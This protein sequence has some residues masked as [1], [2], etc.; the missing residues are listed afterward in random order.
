MTPPSKHTSII[1]LSLHVTRRLLKHAA[2]KDLPLLFCG[3]Y[4]LQPDKYA[5]LH[6]AIA[7]EPIGRDSIFVLKLQRG[8][9]FTIIV[10]RECLVDSRRDSIDRHPNVRMHAF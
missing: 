3:Y 6:V 8:G 2:L 9:A 1:I 7:Q 4:C 10:I 5:V